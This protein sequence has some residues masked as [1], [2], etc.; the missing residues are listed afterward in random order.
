MGIEP[1]Y[2]AWKAD[3]LP[4]SHARDTIDSTYSVSSILI[5]DYRVLFTYNSA[6]EYM[7][8]TKNSQW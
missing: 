7:Y 2:S 8:L 1:T 5:I 3:A 6:I 4:L